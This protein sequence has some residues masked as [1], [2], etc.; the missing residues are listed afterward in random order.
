MSF[1]SLTLI[2]DE[3]EIRPNKKIKLSNNEYINSSVANLLKI[4]EEKVKNNTQDDDWSPNKIF[5]RMA[6][7][8]ANDKDIIDILDGLR[9]QN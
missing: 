8:L 7:L 9:N 1:E 6:Y 3:I 2:N 4:L 5:Q